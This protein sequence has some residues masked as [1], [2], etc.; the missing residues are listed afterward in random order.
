MALRPGKILKIPALK[1]TKSAPAAGGAGAPAKTDHGKVVTGSD[2]QKYYVVSKSDSAGLWG[3]ASKPEVYGKGH[4]YTLIKKAN[5][6][7]DPRLL[8]PGMKLLI[9]PAPAPKREAP[10]ADTGAA[11]VIRDTST[12]VGAGEEIYTVKRGDAGFWGISEKVYGAGKYYALIRDANPNLNPNALKPGTKIII[13][14]LD[15]RKK[16]SVPSGR[17]KSSTSTTSTDIPAG[18]PDFGP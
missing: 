1:T 11:G 5:P 4:L 17:R 12:A 9:P 8:A 16:A 10:V 6:N 15:K 13:P 2:G 18:V 3:I 14:P 7:V